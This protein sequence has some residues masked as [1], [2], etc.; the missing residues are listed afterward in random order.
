MDKKVRILFTGDSIT[1]VY[2]TDLVRGFEDLFQQGVFPA[3]QRDAFLDGMLGTGYP[4]LA[5]SQLTCQQPGRYAV[6][7]RGIS[8]HRV[9]DLDARVKKDCI[10]L[11]PD[12]L[13]I[14]IGIN[15]V[16]HEL[17]GKNG[18]DAAKFRRVYDA[19]LDEIKTALPDVRLILLE[20]YVLQGPATQ[21]SWEYFRRET[22]LRREAVRGLAKKY[23]AARIDTQ[24]LFD[25]AAAR[26][27][28]ADWTADGV[29]PTPAGH[30][31]LAQSWMEVFQL[32]IEPGLR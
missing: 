27:C 31:M 15:D 5:A 17:G 3:E 24:Q 16:W 23:G 10:N 13:S 30:W 22:D 25:A 9:V 8:G 32:E 14:M 1:D 28:A 21:A 29:H 20:P 4:L 7:N 6:L 19:M 26:S 11:E 12:V 2:R 18:V